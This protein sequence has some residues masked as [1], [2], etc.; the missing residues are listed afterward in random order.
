MQKRIGDGFYEQRLIREQINRLDS[1]NQTDT[2]YGVT[3]RVI[4]AV[5]TAGGAT[6]ATGSTLGT[7]GACTGTV[8]SGCIV[9]VPIGAIGAAYGSDLAASG[10]KAVYTGKY[11]SPIG[12]QAFADLTGISQ[13][14]ADLI[15]GA[16]SA[17][18]GVK[19]IA[20]GVAKVGQAAVKEAVEFGNATK[21]VVGELGKDVRATGN[22]IND[23]TTRVGVNTQNSQA[24]T[25]INNAIPKEYKV[26]FG[27]EATTG[28]MVESL[29]YLDGNKEVNLPN[30][31]N[32]GTKLLVDSTYGSLVHKLNPMYGVG[33]D[34][35]KGIVVD[36]K[37]FIISINDSA[38][39]S[40][41]SSFIEGRFNNIKGASNTGKF[42][43]SFGNKYIEYKAEK[44]EE[45]K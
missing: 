13:D 22:Y 2:K 33:A 24:L 38:R 44:K 11:H 12:S 9:A 36:D 17:V 3:T 19:P 30:L 25:N 28:V 39:A 15:Y 43:S 21:Y 40:T 32:S 41:I 14:T 37:N 31:M 35:L 7:I 1:L 10:I 16:P 18:F 26:A 5:Q 23:V 42:I 20:T 27:I 6:I 4:G 34:T 45:N 29:Y 8:G